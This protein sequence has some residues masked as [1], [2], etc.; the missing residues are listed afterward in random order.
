VNHVFPV[1]LSV[2]S[3]CF[4]LFF[5]GTHDKANPSLSQELPPSEEN[6]NKK[7][8]QFLGITE[9]FL[10]LMSTKFSLLS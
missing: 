2:N 6:F 7:I 3:L 9:I 4:L 5:L 8:L 10:L 1:F